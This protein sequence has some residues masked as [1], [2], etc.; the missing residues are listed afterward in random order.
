MLDAHLSAWAV[1]QDL[2]CAVAALVGAGVPAAPAVDPRATSL[3]PQ[4]VARR[5]CEQPEHPVVG[6]VA[7]P[8][9]PFRYAS[10]EHWLTRPAP[11]IGQHN[12]EILGGLLHLEDAEIDALE[13]SGV[14]GSRPTGL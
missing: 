11:T 8:T 6:R 10:V 12:R 5:F 4:I 3:H 13:A 2:D 9:V 14:I 1:E 7:T